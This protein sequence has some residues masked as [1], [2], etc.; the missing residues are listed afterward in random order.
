MAAEKITPEVVQNLKAARELL[1]QPGRWTKRT[2][3]TSGFGEDV[4]V[5]S[6]CALGAIAQVSG[7]GKGASDIGGY[8]K[9]YVTLDEI[10]EVRHLAQALPEVTHNYSSTPYAE[11]VFR[12]NDSPVSD[13][14]HILA[15]FDRAI[16]SA[17]SALANQDT[18]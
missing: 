9:L 5:G 7:L 1:A 12:N 10:C 6:F 17:E 4:P 2:L 8:D 18:E 15:G 14:G 11:R 13:L 3:T 16:Q